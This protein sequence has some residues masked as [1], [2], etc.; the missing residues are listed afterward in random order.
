M[1]VVNWFFLWF[2]VVITNFEVGC[3]MDLDAKKWPDAQI[4][5]SSSF[6]KACVSKLP[7]QFFFFKENTDLWKMN[8]FCPSIKKVSSFL[9]NISNLALF[10]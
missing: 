2:Q 5:D 7:L 6:Y 4:E 10:K 1:L 9:L 3:I 8:E